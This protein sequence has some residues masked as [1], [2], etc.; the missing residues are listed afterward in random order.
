MEFYI[1]YNNEYDKK[2]YNEYDKK[3]YNEYDKKANNNIKKYKIIVGHNPECGM[4]DDE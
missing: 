4:S 1:S 2:E 3:E